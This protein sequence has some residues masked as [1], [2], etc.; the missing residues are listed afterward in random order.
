MGTQIVNSFL[1]YKRSS[2]VH[3]SDNESHLMIVLAH[4]M[5]DH[6]R[7]CNPSISTLIEDTSMSK[8]TL[9]RTVQ[10]LVDRKIIRVDKDKQARR[11][12]FLILLDTSQ[13]PI[14]IVKESPEIYSVRAPIDAL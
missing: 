14:K 2:G 13:E 12:H 7:L 1:K 5:N 11:W 3:F 4:R 10:S 6:S 8:T 9:Y